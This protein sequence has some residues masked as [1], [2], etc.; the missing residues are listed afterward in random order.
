[1]KKI[2]LFMTIKV[3]YSQKNSDIIQDSTFKKP[4]LDVCAFNNYRPITLSSVYA[5]L[6]ELMMIPET[7]ISIN[8]YGYQ[9]HKGADFCCAMLNDLISVYNHADTPVYIYVRWMQRSVL[10]AYGMMD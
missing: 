6:L 7:D 8:Q 2:N 10:T 3:L 9:R 1:M 5:K 4:T